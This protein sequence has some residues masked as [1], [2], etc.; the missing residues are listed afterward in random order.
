MTDA[1]GGDLFKL[2]QSQ[3]IAQLIESLLRDI[4]FGSIELV[5]HD[6]RVVQIEKH[7]KFRL[8]H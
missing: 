8:N 5:V 1:E 7:E 3:N 2:A 6:G 4:R